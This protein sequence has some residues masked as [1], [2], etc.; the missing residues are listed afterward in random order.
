[1]ASCGGGATEDSADVPT[2]EG[3]DHEDGHDHADGEEHSH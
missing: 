1:M 3:H 2:E